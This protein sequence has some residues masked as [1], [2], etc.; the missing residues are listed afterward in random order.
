MVNPGTVE[1]P[2]FFLFLLNLQGF[3]AILPVKENFRHGK[4]L[5]AL[6]CY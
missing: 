2:G 4:K 1:V 5:S 3:F 6:A